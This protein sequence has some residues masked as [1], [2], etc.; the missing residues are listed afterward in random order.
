MFVITARVHWGIRSLA[1]ARNAEKHIYKSTSI[2]RVE[3]NLAPFS[4]ELEYLVLV[5]T[6]GYGCQLINSDGLADEPTDPPNMTSQVQEF[7]I[8][9][10]S[11]SGLEAV[12]NNRGD[13]PMCSPS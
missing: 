6:V 8:C 13:K 11:L 12:H 5:E 7:S 2:R 9:G 4:Q 1:Y 3:R 10:I